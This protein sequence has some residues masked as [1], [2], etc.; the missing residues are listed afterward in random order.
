MVNENL[1]CNNQPI[2]RLL[3]CI[4]PKTTAKHLSCIRM[5][6]EEELRWSCRCNQSIQT[7]KNKILHF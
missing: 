6:T 3:A 1:R 2:N 4:L 7:I 5:E